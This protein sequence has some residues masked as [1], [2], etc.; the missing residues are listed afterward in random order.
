MGVDVVVDL[1]VI[2]SYLGWVRVTDMEWIGLGLPLLWS[3]LCLSDWSMSGCWDDEFGR[4]L[5]GVV[6]LSEDLGAMKRCEILI[7]SA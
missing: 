5:D 4:S 7:V 6:F 2:G 1:I 3:Q